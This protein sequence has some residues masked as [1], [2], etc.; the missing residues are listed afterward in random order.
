[1]SWHSSHSTP[2]MLSYSPA[3]SLAMYLQSCQ[4]LS[5]FYPLPPSSLH[6]SSRGLLLTTGSI[7]SPACW[8]RVCVCVPPSLTPIGLGANRCV[9]NLKNCAF[10][11]R[12]GNYRLCS[13]LKADVHTNKNYW[14]LRAEELSVWN[15]SIVF[16]GYDK[17]SKHTMYKLNR[18]IISALNYCFCAPLA[19]FSQQLTY[20]GQKKGISVLWSGVHWG[21]KERSKEEERK[22]R[23]GK[24]K[25]ESISPF[26]WDEILF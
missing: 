25:N 26:R 16:Y 18:C 19:L 14:M 8:L 21:A 15:P 1:M 5:A 7:K 24:G 6:K 10:L 22:E 2:T 23:M 12:Q 4:L 13:L 11:R 20:P 3:A 17:Q 9:V